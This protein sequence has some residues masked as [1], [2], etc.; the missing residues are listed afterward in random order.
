M[1]IPNGQRITRAGKNIFVFKSNPNGKTDPQESDAG[2]K[3]TTCGK[4]M[5]EN[6]SPAIWD[7]DASNGNQANLFL[8]TRSK[9]FSFAWWSTDLYAGVNLSMC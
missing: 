1:C 6:G 8:K 4:K 9:Y 5:L 2:L 7:L 3:W